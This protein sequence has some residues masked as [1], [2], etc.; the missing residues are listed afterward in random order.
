MTVPSVSLSPS[1]SDSVADSARAAVFLCLGLAASQARTARPTVSAAYRLHQK[2]FATMLIESLSMSNL[3]AF[4]S[5]KPP[6]MFFLAHSLILLPI[7][8]L[9]VVGCFWLNVV[10]ARSSSSS[11]SAL[12][13][14]STY[15]LSENARWVCFRRSN[16]LIRRR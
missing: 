13:G 9:V 2:I 1:P 10:R 6:R 3:P 4:R 5:A 14:K 8:T 7:Y 11:S 15:R 12:G 16:Y